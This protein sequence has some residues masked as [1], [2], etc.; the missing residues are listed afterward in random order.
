MQSI[1]SSPN[2]SEAL[3]E[4]KVEEALM[5]DPSIAADIEKDGIAMQNMEKS[6]EGCLNTIEKKYDN[7]FTMDNEKEVQKKLMDVMK[8]KANCAV[9]YNLAKLGGLSQ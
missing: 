6:M 7:V 1:L 3:I 4:K 2:L 8:S 5:A 9:F